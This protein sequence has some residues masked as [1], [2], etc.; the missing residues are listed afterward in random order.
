[1]RVVV[2]GATGNVGTSLVDVLRR[3][4]RVNEIVGVARRPPADAD[5]LV[6]YV[7]GDIAR[8]DLRPVMAGADVVVHLAWLFQPTHR[9]LETWHAN[10]EGSVRVLDAVADGG[11][12]ML[13]Y[14]S[15]VGAY[16]PAPRRRV[17][18]SWP[19][20]SLPTAAYGREKAY[21]ERLLD[22]F[23]ARHP[24]VRLVRLRPAFIFKRAAATKQRRILLGPF[25]PRRIGRRGL[26]PFL[27]LPSELAF[28]AVHSDDVAEAIRLSLTSAAEGAFNL[29]ADDVLDASVIAAVL[30]TKHV[31]LPRTVTRAAL[32]A[33]WHAHLAPA[34]PALLDLVL[35][36]PL[37]DTSRA[38][39]ELG[40]VPRWSGAE[41]LGE[42]LLGMEQGAGAPT[43]ALEPD[44]GD[45]RRREVA[46][47]V[48]ENA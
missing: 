16:S 35:G 18:E 26:L 29:A 13:V 43:A 45:A 25:V 37:L 10:V 33:T 41:A 40:W 46:T 47:G 42:M 7:A 23:E 20:H 44:S 19:T 5:P 34:D 27:P 4:R 2:L 36:L 17:D 6:T 9:P 38:R 1:M 11:V 12:S 30:G 32:A 28:Q 15:S 48:G 22:G 21:V 14:A 31:P 3:D 8:D 39:R 24:H